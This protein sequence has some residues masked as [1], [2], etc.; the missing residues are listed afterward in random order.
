MHEFLLVTLVVLHLAL[1]SIGSY[2][3]FKK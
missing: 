2:R 3:N 1:I